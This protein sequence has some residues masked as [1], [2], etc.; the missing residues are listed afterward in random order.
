VWGWEDR[1][2]RLTAKTPQ[3]PCGHPG[4]FKGG[5]NEHSR[6]LPEAH[7]RGG[8]KNFLG[9]GKKGR[10]SNGVALLMLK[11]KLVHSEC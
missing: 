1:L 3:R 8:E 4:H 5:T 2:R 9:G 10:A 6:F 11:K 7:R